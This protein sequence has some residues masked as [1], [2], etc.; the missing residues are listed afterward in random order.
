M[1]REQ[2]LATGLSWKVRTSEPVAYDVIETVDL[3]EPGNPLLMTTSG[4]RGS[5][6][7]FVAVDE[8]LLDSLADPLEKY[9]AQYG[10]TCQLLS[11]PAGEANK[12]L[13]AFQLVS[14]A[15]DGFGIQRRNEPVLAVGG[16]VVTDLVGFAASCYRRGV[17]YVRVPT[18]V[19]GYVDAAIGIKT[20]INHNGAK[21]RI[22]SFAA[23]VATLLDRRF[24]RTLP[25]RH[26]RNGVGEMLKL[27]VIKDADL[28]AQL[29]RDGP[30]AVEDRFQGSGADLLHGA[31]RG[32]LEELEPNLHEAN[33]ER[34]MD[35]GHTFSPALEMS[36]LGDLLHGEAVAIDV[37]L[38][39]M[40]SRVR[41]M[42]DEATCDRVLQMSGRLG[43]PVGHPGV[44]PSLLWEGLQERSAHR[45]GRQR[46]P[47]VE[48]LGRCAF[49]NDITL[50]QLRAAC[51]ALSD[52]AERDQ[53]RA[54]RY[55]AGHQGN[56]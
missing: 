4:G 7:R 12:D 50:G 18:T 51:R 35:F 36:H 5:A 22:G 33:L 9:F 32:M 26:V 46:V 3:L 20:G 56:R 41:G 21:N 15:L 30:G 28:F 19:M 16:G 17:P 38:S 31:I 39:M 13:R 23:P 34:A 27:A 8:A 43:L 44:R 40:L 2:S 25:L 37:A 49:V 29:E 53:A 14:D 11:V 45:N 52:W 55:G 10:A 6:R 47:L 48:G 1:L 24:L 42:V 54:D